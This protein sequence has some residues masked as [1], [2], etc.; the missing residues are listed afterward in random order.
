[1]NV[2]LQKQLVFAPPGALIDACALRT[3]WHSALSCDLGRYR[4]K[5]D[6]SSLSA[7]H[8]LLSLC[9]PTALRSTRGTHHHHQSKEDPRLEAASSQV[10]QVE[11]KASIKIEGRRKDS[12]FNFSFIV[13]G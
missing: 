6:F 8:R 3:P 4:Q 2:Y 11:D 5:S 9:V 1:M 13:N 10:S 7:L 12:C